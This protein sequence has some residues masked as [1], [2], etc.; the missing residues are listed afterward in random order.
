V[1]KFVD[2]TTSRERRDL[3]FMRDLL[4]EKERLHDER[5]RRQSEMVMKREKEIRDDMKQ[6]AAIEARN[7]RSTPKTPGSVYVTTKFTG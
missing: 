7:C 4:K 1:T 6:L 2:E 5:E 3:D